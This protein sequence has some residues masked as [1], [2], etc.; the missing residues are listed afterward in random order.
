MQIGR[1]TCEEKVLKDE[2]EGVRVFNER[3]VQVAFYYGAYVEDTGGELYVIKQLVTE[4]LLGFVVKA[5]VFEPLP[6]PMVTAKEIEDFSGLNSLYAAAQADGISFESEKLRKGATGDLAYIKDKAEQILRWISDV[7]FDIEKCRAQSI[8]EL[9]KLFQQYIGD[10]EKR[11][12]KRI[13]EGAWKIETCAEC[14]KKHSL[15][16][17]LEYTPYPTFAPYETAWR[18]CCPW[19]Y[20]P[21]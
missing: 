10:S 12:R 6:S 11:A 5:P 17:R 21:L 1:Y 14:G 18:D 2:S 3:G 19:C 16:I 4:Q 13:K 9:I 15:P 8:E 7:S 20:K